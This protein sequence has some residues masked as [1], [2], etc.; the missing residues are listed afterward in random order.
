MYMQFTAP[1]PVVTG[2]GPIAAPTVAAASSAAPPTVVPWV[3]YGLEILGLA[4]L[5]GFEPP[6]S[7]AVVG[8]QPCSCKKDG[9]SGNLWWIVGLVVAVA[10]A[11]KGY[12][13]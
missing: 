1:Q 5:G 12:S 6:W 4:G 13:E 9:G 7:D 11:V 2:S 10:I 8:Q 3:D